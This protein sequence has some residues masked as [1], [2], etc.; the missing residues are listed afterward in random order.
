MPDFD[1]FFEKLDAL[2]VSVHRRLD[3]NFGWWLIAGLTF[4][5]T[6]ST[7]VLSAWGL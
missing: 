3:R 7:L 2:Q 5:I 1:R 6:A 4:S